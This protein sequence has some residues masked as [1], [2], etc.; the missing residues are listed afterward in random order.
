MFQFIPCITG[1][2]KISHLHVM[3][4]II[5]LLGCKQN[6]ILF[7]LLGYGLLSVSVMLVMI[8]VA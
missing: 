3:T 7:H 2:F 1:Y 6:S 5:I 8:F 4:V